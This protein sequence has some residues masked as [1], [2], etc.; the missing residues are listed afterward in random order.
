MIDFNDWSLTVP[1]QDPVR[2]VSAQAITSGYQD[3]YFYRTDNGVVFWAPVTGTSTRGSSYPRSELRE[4]NSKGQQRNWYIRDGQH[5]LRAALAVKQLPSS[6]RIVIGQVHTKDGP[7]PLLKILYQQVN[8]TGYVYAELR[9]KPG[10][11]QSPRVLTY[12]GMPL[13]S[14]F[15][16]EIDLSK[17]GGLRIDINGMVYTGKVNSA[18]AKRRMYFKAGVYTLDNKGPSSEGGRVE[19]YDLQASHRT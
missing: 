7:A 17:S 9:E 16:Y 3:R 14:S 18:W 5:E 19:F 4:T 10:S 8:G 12:K 1:E 13:G 2:V 15:T 6:G 11:K